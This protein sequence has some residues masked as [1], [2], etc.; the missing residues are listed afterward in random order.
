MRRYVAIAMVVAFFAAAASAALPGSG[1]VEAQLSGTA[2]PGGRGTVR[3][4]TPVAVRQP[5]C[6]LTRF[7]L[8]GDGRILRDD[9]MIMLRLVEA[10][11][12]PD[13]NNGELVA[14]CAR[15]DFN[16]DGRVDRADLQLMLDHL[17][18]CSPTGRLT[19]PPL[20][21]N[22]SGTPTRLP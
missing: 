14:L 8:T 19:K 13:P 7:E 12:N 18:I 17:A 9:V 3:A 22:L 20:P 16:G 4:L 10:C 15:A 5:V 11:V 6:D 2:T 1:T 21:P